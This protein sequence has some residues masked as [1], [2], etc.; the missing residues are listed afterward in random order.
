MSTWKPGLL[1]VTDHLQVN[2]CPCCF[3]RNLIK[4]I[5]PRRPQKN[6]ICFSLFYTLRVLANVMIILN[7]KLLAKV[8]AKIFHNYNIVLIK[9]RFAFKNIVSDN[10]S[11]FKSG[12]YFFKKLIFCKRWKTRIVF[13]QIYN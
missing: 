7:Y 2:Y 3:C 12:C 8:I 9:K 13:T 5:Q 10:L 4:K 6:L 1:H 11:E